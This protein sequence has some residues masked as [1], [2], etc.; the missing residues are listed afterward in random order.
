MLTIFRS[1]LR[2]KLA[3][4]LIGLLI[5]SLSVW[6]LSDIFSPKLGNSLVKVGGR[7]VEVADVNRIADSQLDRINQNGTSYTRQDLA[8]AGQ[9][10]GIVGAL[11]NREIVAAYFEKLGLDASEEAVRDQ[12]RQNPNFRSEINGGFDLALYQRFLSNRRMSENAFIQSMRDDLTIVSINDG[13]YGALKAP[14]A[15]TD[16]ISIAEGEARRVAYMIITQDNLPETIATPSDEEIQTFYNEQ[17]SALTQPERRGFSVIAVTP[18][19]FIHQVSV[20]DEELRNDYEAQIRRFS[21]PPTRTFQTMVAPT[22]ANAR[23]ALGR[24]QGGDEMSAVNSRF[25]TTLLPV[26]TSLQNEISSP[27][28]AS[29]IF[30]APVGLWTGPVSLPDGRW[31]LVNVSS[32]TEGEPIPFEQVE[33]TIRNEM[34]QLK[35][36]R[37]YSASFDNIDDA[38]G[39]G[40]TLGELADILGSPIYTYPPVDQ[41]GRTEAGQVI[42]NLTQIEGALD[43]GFQL[44]PDETSFRQDAGETQFIIRLNE[45]VAPRVPPLGDI[46]EDLARVIEARKTQEA[47][48]EF[49]TG[50]ATRISDGTAFLTTEADALGVE[51]TRPPEALRKDSAQSTGFSREAMIKIFASNLDKPFTVQLQNGLFVG[52]VEAIEIPDAQSLSASR[53]SSD[54]EVANS[55]RSDIEQGLLTLAQ[56]NIEYQMNP[57]AIDAYVKDNQSPQ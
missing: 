5:L 28:L 13:L 15:L 29:A 33:A 48:M 31:A 54:V 56:Q 25:N 55:L 24:L 7:T 36:E 6:G 34:I 45:V 37:M 21:G 11:A 17:Q 19:D 3:V 10:N 1:M 57:A 8:D 50:I 2:S 14:K 44:F 41:S 22:E 27:V 46:K 35:A 9:L 23:G 49:G 53:A 12:I 26:E 47:L 16:L 18:Q 20:T 40:A 38:V 32:E 30:N 4:I 51:V 52:V 42:R 39:S 43:Y